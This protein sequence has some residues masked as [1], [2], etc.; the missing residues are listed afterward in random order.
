MSERTHGCWLDLCEGG[1]PN[2]CVFENGEPVENCCVAIKLRADGKTQWA[3]EYWKPLNPEQPSEVE[4]L[5]AEIARLRITD[6]EREAL[7]RICEAAD[8]IIDE[9]KRANGVYWQDDAAAVA[10]VRGLLERLGG[11]R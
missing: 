4:S 3:C 2:G 9:D 8:D 7:E 10:V 5:R 11:G 6:K 1:T